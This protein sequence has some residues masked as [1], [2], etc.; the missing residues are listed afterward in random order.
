[1]YK[2]SRIELMRF[3]RTGLTL[4]NP[5]FVNKIEHFSKFFKKRWILT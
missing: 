5:F 2:L 3:L 4:A 1:M